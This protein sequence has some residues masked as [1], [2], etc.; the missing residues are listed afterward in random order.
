MS[1]S[2]HTY[3]HTQ[4]AL[5]QVYVETGTSHLVQAKRFQKKARRCV[6]FL[7]VVL[8]LVGVALAIVMGITL[9]HH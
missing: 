6:C 1:T 3:K 2:T 8:V 7:L 5:S 4:V 9:S